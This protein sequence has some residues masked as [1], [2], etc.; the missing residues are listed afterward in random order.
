M[1]DRLLPK[2]LR[3]NLLVRAAERR[4]RA[5]ARRALRALVEDIRA[6]AARS[7]YAGQGARWPG[8]EAAV[9][10]DL[11][12]AIRNT[13]EQSYLDLV[14]GL[15]AESMDARPNADN[16]LRQIDNRLVRAADPVWEHVRA[17][18]RD[19]I[20]KAEAMPDLAKRVDASLR[21]LGAENWSGRAETIAR[22]ET[23]GAFNN[24]RLGAGRALARAVGIPER[25]V[26]KAWL[27]TRTDHRTRP[28]HIV[29]DGQTVRLNSRF[30]VGGAV[31]WS[32]GDPTL[33]ASEC[34]NC[35]CTVNILMPGD[36]GYPTDAQPSVTASA[37]LRFDFNPAQKRGPDGRWVKY[38]TQK[39]AFLSLFMPAYNQDDKNFLTVSSGPHFRQWMRDGQP[40][41]H[42]MAP[43]FN[44]ILQNQADYRSRQPKTSDNALFWYRPSRYKDKDFPTAPKV[45]DVIQDQAP[46][47]TEALKPSHSKTAVVYAVRVPAGSEGILP[48]PDDGKYGYYVGA[49]IPPGARLQVADVREENGQTYVTVDLLPAHHTDPAPV[50]PTP[51]PAPVPSPAPSPDIKV[52]DRITNEQVD[53]LPVGTRL[54]DAGA[55]GITYER[56]ADGWH[57]KGGTGDG[58]V[59]D[60][61]PSY[62]L[63][64]LAIGTGDTAPAPGPA[65]SPEPP[66]WAKTGTILRR[67][68]IDALPD[69]SQVST[70]IRSGEPTFWEKRDGL[71]AV[72]SGK[73][74]RFKNPPVGARLDRY[75]PGDNSG[76]AKVVVKVGDKVEQNRLDSL[77]DGTII[78]AATYGDDYI[79]V[80]G[81]WQNVDMRKEPPEGYGTTFPSHAP[82]L[83]GSSQVIRVAGEGGGNPNWRTRAWRKLMSYESS[84]KAKFADRLNATEDYQQIKTADDLKARKG[85]PMSDAEARDPAHPTNPFNSSFSYDDDGQRRK[86]RQQIRDPKEFGINCQ[87]ASAAYELRRRGYRVT[88]GMGSGGATD[89]IGHM[90]VD[91]NGRTRE[92]ENFNSPKALQAK[93]LQEGEGSRFLVYGAWKG[94]RG[95]HIWNAEVVDGKLVYHESQVNRS[96][97]NPTPLVSRPGVAGGYDSE[98]S[99]R[100][101]AGYA[102]VYLMRVDDLEPSENMFDSAFIHSSPEIQAD[103]VAPKVGEVG[104]R[105]GLDLLP[106][107]TKIKSGGGVVFIRRI[108][109]ETGQPGWQRNN[110]VWIDNPAATKPVVVSIP[111]A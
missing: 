74:S 50:V 61:P 72:T 40:P 38:L 6:Y 20:A 26:Y 11:G 110:G 66:D 49:Q 59:H 19:G 89:D 78:R 93:A 96:N 68:Q 82:I 34:V 60:Q 87:R 92:F 55:A 94:G 83:K 104:T 9:Q 39:A 75:G 67:D 81:G 103:A 8:W 37:L 109:P 76:D 46:L 23:I 18:L 1:A 51:E 45:G 63:T 44:V 33:P 90:W 3:D 65:P 84:R 88:A 70:G 15:D 106:V 41:S 21:E 73:P 64:V 85:A 31:A 5:S 2:R 69:G 71:W 101:A 107:G 7:N 32:P 42:V 24:G 30:R 53:G 22:T 80:P 43:A 95:A 48:I 27:S 10:G 100:G 47:T 102:G 54:R 12:P 14:A 25:D 13:Y 105:K 57:Q 58:E 62:L 97:P 16:Y 111:K 36:R 29:A 99:Y 86:D 79:K 98:I 56:K 108:N 52:G 28:T 17:N 35:R 77:P 4:V 91:S